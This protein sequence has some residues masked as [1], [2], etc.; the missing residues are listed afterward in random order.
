MTTSSDPAALA[1]LLEVARGSALLSEADTGDGVVVGRVWFEAVGAEVRVE[2]DQ[3][4]D[5]GDDAPPEDLVAALR[6]VLQL[7]EGRWR[8]LVDDIAAEIEGAVGDDDVAE[9]T[10]LRDDLTLES[11]DVVGDAV[12]LTFAAPRQFPDSRIHVQLDEELEIE[13]LAVDDAE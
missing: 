2:L 7:P 5:D 3:E 8:G 13:D 9:T 4:L 1:R 10:D 12:L 11:I 6:R